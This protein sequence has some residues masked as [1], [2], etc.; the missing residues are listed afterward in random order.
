[1]E[2]YGKKM[3]GKYRSEN[4]MERKLIKILEIKRDGRRGHFDGRKP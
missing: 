2:S 3:A 1:M 4:E